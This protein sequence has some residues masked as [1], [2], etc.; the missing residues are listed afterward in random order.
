MTYGTTTKP[1]ATN[2]FGT[3]SVNGPVPPDGESDQRQ[4]EGTVI[5]GAT[6]A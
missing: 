4:S 5:A 1:V 2:S 6:D 3:G